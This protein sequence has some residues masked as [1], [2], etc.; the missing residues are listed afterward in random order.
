MRD[1]LGAVTAFGL[2]ASV[3]LLVPGLGLLLLPMGAAGATRLVIGAAT[4]A[5][6]A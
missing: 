5:P 3:T 6:K 1:N 2:L 4:P